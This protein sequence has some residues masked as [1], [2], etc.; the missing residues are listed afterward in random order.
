MNAEP[1]GS[2]NRTERPI[3]WAY[4]DGVRYQ[5]AGK[6]P[7]WVAK[8]P[9]RVSD[10]CR[11]VNPS[12]LAGTTLVAVEAAAN[13]ASGKTVLI[14]S[15]IGGEH[16]SLD[17]FVEPVRILDPERRIASR[18][19]SPEARVEWGSIVLPV[20]N[21]KEARRTQSSPTAPNGFGRELE[22]PAPDVPLIVEGLLWHARQLADFGAPT[23]AVEALLD[24]VAAL[25]EGRG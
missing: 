7:A 24:H 3:H 13:T 25:R 23:E 11:D 8:D 14:E 6:L 20:V 15:A 5:D 2:V 4:P 18:R 22:L 9:N 10:A 16:G 17:P 21:R 19:P 1:F 12:A